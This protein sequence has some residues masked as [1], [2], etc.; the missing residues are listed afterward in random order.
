MLLFEHKHHYQ[1]YNVKRSKQRKIFPFKENDYKKWLVGTTQHS[2]R[3][4]EITN[5]KMY[6]NPAPSSMLIRVEHVVHMLS[7]LLESLHL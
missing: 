4:S 3:V 2:S 7:L 5:P 6:L 1:S